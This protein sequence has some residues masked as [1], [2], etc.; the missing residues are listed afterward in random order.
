MK[1]PKC[2]HFNDVGAKFCAECSAPLTLTCSHC[3]QPILATAK[4]CSE[5]GRPNSVSPSAASPFGAP[6]TYTPKHLVAKV[7]NS[8]A[9]LEGERKQ[10]TVL[11]ADLKG[12]MELLAD[13]DPEEA[14]KLLDPVLELMMEAVHHY[15]GTV[16]QAA[17]DGI[18]ALFGAPLAH[19][20]HAQRACFAA[21][22]LRDELR[23]YAQELR[24]TQGLD[25]AVRIGLNSG[26]VV[27]GK[28]GDDLRMDYTAQGHTVGLAARMEQ[29]AE[30]GK[31]LLT[32]HAAKLAPGYFAVRDLGP[33]EL[34]GVSAP[35]RCYELEG[36]GTLHTPL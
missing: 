14:R 7:L 9:A 24:R 35:I 36:V 17:G 4:F 16:N 21:L 23:G 12:S 20:D 13:R 28:I 27:V 26:E 6:E 5:C 18:M 11:F 25:F 1:C 3:N 22:R 29:L 10:V 8:R 2:Q 31:T 15:E 33:F 34:K 30:A 32:E 19:E